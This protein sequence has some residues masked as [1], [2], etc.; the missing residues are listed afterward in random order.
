MSE[1]GSLFDPELNIR[2]ENYSKYHSTRDNRIILKKVKK[3]DKCGMRERDIK[4]FE[5]DMKCRT[6][7]NKQKQ[8]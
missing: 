7:K 6:K 8:F 5:N 1:I 2:Y 4:G 3:I